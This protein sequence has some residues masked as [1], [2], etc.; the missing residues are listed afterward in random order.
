MQFEFRGFSDNSGDAEADAALAA[1]R[2]KTVMNLL[3]D[4][5]TPPWRMKA[6]AM[7][8]DEKRKSMVVFVRT[9]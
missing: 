7:P 6:T 3:A 8:A 1:A 5:G 4:N 2:A 9:H